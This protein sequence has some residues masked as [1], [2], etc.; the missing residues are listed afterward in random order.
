M[1]TR[2][3]LTYT[4][5]LQRHPDG[6]SG[7]SELIDGELVV[8]PSPTVRHQRVVKILTR[9]LDDYSAQAG[10]EAFGIPLDVYASETNVLEPDV[11]YAGPGKIGP[12]DERPL[13]DVDFVVE[14][15]SP[16]TRRYDL[17]RKKQ[18]YEEIEVP[19]Y[20]FVDLDKEA[21]LVHSLEDGRYGSVRVY[22]RGETLVSATLPGLQVAVDDIF[23]N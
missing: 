19:E 4:E 23:A 3:G 17:G 2:S 22:H 6:L 1:A 14:V 7:R 12:D 13:H 8:S 18:L 20:W 21:I 9:L 10:G 16:S 5:I 15:S 11:L